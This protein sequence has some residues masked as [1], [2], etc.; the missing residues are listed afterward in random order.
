MEIKSTINQRENNF[1]R[2]GT[3]LH[4]SLLSIPLLNTHT[5]YI[6]S[7]ERIRHE[8]CWGSSENHHKVPWVAWNTILVPKK[9]RGAR[10]VPLQLRIK[11][12]YVNGIQ[13]F[14]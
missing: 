12:N 14:E 13:I 11:L 2:V 3:R 6:E 5:G 1:D 8:F 4:T 9:A 10:L 7:L